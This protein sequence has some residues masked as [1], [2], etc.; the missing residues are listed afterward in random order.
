VSSEVVMVVVVDMTQSSKISIKNSN[1]PTFEI[2]LSID[3]KGRL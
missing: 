2:N 3:V 1:S